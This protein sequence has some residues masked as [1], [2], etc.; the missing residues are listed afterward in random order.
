MS[1]LTN[2]AKWSNCS[3]TFA[4][5]KR[6]SV[7]TLRR[8]SWFEIDADGTTIC[9]DEELD[10]I[11]NEVYQR[12]RNG[13]NIGCGWVDYPTYFDAIAA[14]NDAARRAIADGAWKPED[15]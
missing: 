8:W 3:Y 2:P 13:K 15:A 6:P 10:D 12:L 11:P 1:S 5:G 14:A 4:T 7:N 9:E